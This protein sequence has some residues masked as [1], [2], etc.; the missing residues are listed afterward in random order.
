MKRLISTNAAIIPLMAALIFATSCIAEAPGDRFYRT[1]WTTEDSPLDGLTLEF[2]CDGWISAQALK[3]SS[4]SYGR[5]IPDGS[6]VIFTD[7]HVVFDTFTAV[8]EGAHRTD[9][10]LLIS[11][12][13]VE[14]PTSAHALSQTEGSRLALGASSEASTGFSSDV[15]SD[16]STDISTGVSSDA[17]TDFSTGVSSDVS[18]TTP[19]HRISDYQ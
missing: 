15:S 11:W 6:D 12:H 13:M 8:I 16:A 3:A 14:L 5:Y 2:L 4:G 17:S 10:T 18:Y 7:L 9:D 1:L 19:L